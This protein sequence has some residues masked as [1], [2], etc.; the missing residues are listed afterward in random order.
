M[1]VI[2]EGGEKANITGKD[3]AAALAPNKGRA[4]ELNKEVIA[5]R[6]R[7]RK[8][9]GESVFQADLVQN[10]ADLMVNFDEMRRVLDSERK[11]VSTETDKKRKDVLQKRYDR[12]ELRFGMYDKLLNNEGLASMDDT[13][14]QELVGTMAR[15][16]GFAE[17]A[18]LATGGRLSTDQ[19]M[20]VLEGK[21]GVAMTRD[22]KK[23]V[24]EIVANMA[25]DD[26]FKNRVSKSLSELKLSDDDAK[27]TKDIDDLKYKIKDKDEA[28]KKLDEVKKTKDDYERAYPT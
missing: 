6:E 20:R 25:D 4:P 1:A 18:S 11:R 16:P 24:T 2:G 26:R 23:V 13:E 8:D 12:L 27:I 15:L 10:E 3:L 22:E 14:K 21:G 9:A 17:A 19:M 7:Y 5:L 28:Q